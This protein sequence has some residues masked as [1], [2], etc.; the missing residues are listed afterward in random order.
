MK[1]IKTFLLSERTFGLLIAAMLIS[2][3]LPYAYST[4]VLIVLLACSAGSAYFHKVTLKKSQLLPIAF[5]LFMILSMIWTN[6]I[7]RSLRG[8]ERQLPFLLIPLIFLL[9]PEISRRNV[10]RA[11][12]SFAVAL[13]LL[14]CILTINAFV[15]YSHGGDPNVFFYHNILIPMDLNAI[16]VSAM[17]SLSLLYLIF[18]S[19]RRLFDWVISG[20][21]FSFLIL[22]SSKNLIVI[23]IFSIIIGLILSNKKNI[24]SLLFALAIVVTALVVVFFSPLKNRL[25]QELTSNVKEVLTCEKFN[26]V[27][28]WTGT[29]IRLFQA[30]VG[31]ELLK[32]NDA[33]LLGF[34]LNVSKEKIIQ[35]QNDYN[36][37]FGYNDYNFHNQYIQA[38]V[39]LGVFGFI[40]IIFLL[41]VIFNGYLKKRE[42]LAV[43][44]FIVMLS[45]FMTESYLWRQ[46]GLFH[47]LIIYGLL[48][49]F[50]PISLNKV[51]KT[52]N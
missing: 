5:Y 48:S 19:K 44:F 37:Y 10:K 28:P 18:Y 49:T 4:T 43:F 1:S 31:Y 2:L 52:D 14:A 47:F 21:L 11:L 33:F 17:T 24:K 26:R 46:R 42:I 32:E 20:I 29:T 35:K 50:K 23:T 3:P 9:M 16:Y 39:E 41:A 40:F 6:D 25:D 15:L 51:Q 12:Y 45:V 34:G 7:Q 38:F 36:L 8:L 30:R 27:Y 13:A 22:L